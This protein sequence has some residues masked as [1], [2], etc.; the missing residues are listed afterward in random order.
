MSPRPA[1]IAEGS[2]SEAIITNVDVAATFFDV[3]G[4]DAAE[5]MPTSPEWSLRRIRAE[6]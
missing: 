6:G 3:R 2:R 1:A 5:A 4:I